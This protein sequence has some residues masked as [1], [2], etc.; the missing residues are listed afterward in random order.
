M[1]K[2]PNKQGVW[3][4]SCFPKSMSFDVGFQ[5]KIVFEVP[6]GCSVGSINFHNHDQLNML[7]WNPRQGEGNTVLGTFNNGWE[8]EERYLH[9]N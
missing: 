8:A 2:A 5:F 7:H 3:V 1:L 9:Q 4:G 6:S